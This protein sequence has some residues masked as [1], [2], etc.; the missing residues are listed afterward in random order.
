MHLSQLAK[1]R[2]FK[3]L[4]AQ[5]LQLSSFSDGILEQRGV[6]ETLELTTLQ[7]FTN[8]RK[9]IVAIECGS[10]KLLRFQNL[11]HCDN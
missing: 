3:H 6:D 1:G 2:F 11:I 10:T 4:Q 5:S 9:N 7:V 8:F